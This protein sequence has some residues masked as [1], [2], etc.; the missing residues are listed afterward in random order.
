M[1]QKVENVG[2]ALSNLNQHGAPVTTDVNGTVY[3]ANK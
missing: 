2:I 1:A 3:P